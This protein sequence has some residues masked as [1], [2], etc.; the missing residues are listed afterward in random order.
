MAIA[1]STSLVEAVP[2]EVA[3]HVLAFLQH[4]GD[5]VPHPVARLL[6]ADVVEQQG[7]RE[8]QRDGVRDVLARDVGG[9]AVH[10]LEDGALLADVGAGGEARGRR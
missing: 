9:A 5:R 2:A 3:R 4:R 7:A 1:S 10:R 8:D 6:L